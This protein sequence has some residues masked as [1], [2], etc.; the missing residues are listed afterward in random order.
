MTD[1]ELYKLAIKAMEYSYS[2]YSDFTVGAALLTE[3]GRV[4]RGANIENSSYGATVCAERT[5]VYNAV[6]QGEKGFCAIA[7]VGGKNKNISQFCYPCGICRQVLSEF[8]DGDFKVIL[9]DGKEI[10][11]TALNRLLPNS[12]G[13]ENL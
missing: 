8:C 10:R 4:F 5:A 13:S 11:E 12:F 3:S 7:V 2:P 9:F 1:K 6:S